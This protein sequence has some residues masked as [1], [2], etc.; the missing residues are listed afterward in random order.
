MS[1]FSVSA[2]FRNNYSLSTKNSCKYLSLTLFSSFSPVQSYGVVIS[3][4]TTPAPPPDADK[5]AKEKGGVRTA[6]KEKS[7]IVTAVLHAEGC[8]KRSLAL[9]AKL[10]VELEEAK[11]LT[12]CEEVR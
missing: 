2:A 12:A 1:D 6:G 11:M 7:A 5:T 4:V 10:S 8:C 9:A 3:T